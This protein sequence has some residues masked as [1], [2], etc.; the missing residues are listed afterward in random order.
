MAALILAMDTTGE[1]GSVALA[2]GG[3]LIECR[4]IHAQQ[5]FAAVIF[6]AL[7]EL[8]AANGVALDE[9][10]LYA[11]AAGPGS[12]TGVRVGLAAC[13]GLAIAGAKRVA[14]ISNLAATA[15]MAPEGPRLLIPVLDAR[16]GEFYAAAYDREGRMV[17]PEV[18]AGPAALEERLAAL[19]LSA[20]DT[21]F[22]GPEVERLPLQ[23]FAGVT[24]PRG[25]FPRVTFPRVT[26]GRALAAAVAALAWRDYRAGKTATAESAD[27]NY[28]RRSD[29]EVVRPPATPGAKAPGWSAPRNAAMVRVRLL[30]AR[31]AAMAAALDRAA[32]GAAHWPA[33][34]YERLAREQ[35]EGGATRF[36]LLAEQAGGPP[37]GDTRRERSGLPAGLLAASVAGGEAEVLNLAVAAAHR[38][39]GV[40]T[41][42]LDEALR[43]ARQRGAASVW[44]EVRESNLTAIAFYRRRG[45]AERGRRRG[46]YSSP[47]EDALVLAID[48][49]NISS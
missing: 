22:C 44:L 24:F 28:V 2:R 7:G 37:A 32:E 19:N 27:A 4:A 8:L 38:R 30:R 35:D 29:A 14:A 9:V 46:Y 48:L 17:M 40:A 42:L 5:T 21:V 47:G 16:R 3:E 12:F 36:C 49:K 1:H 31:E 18:V 6:G 23:G 15:A 13:K 26:T 11:A 20:D 39:R 41:A 43:T 45:F 25:T 10:A 33:A 34:D